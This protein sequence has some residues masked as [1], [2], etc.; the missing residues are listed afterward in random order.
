[1]EDKSHIP[2][3]ERMPQSYTEPGAPIEQE[4]DEDMD[5]E[6][7]PSQEVEE[8]EITDEEKE[9]SDEDTEMVDAPTEEKNIIDEIDTTI[10][11]NQPGSVKASEKDEDIALDVEEAQEEAEASD[12]NVVTR[13]EMPD[14][15][16]STLRAMQTPGM[17]AEDEKYDG[18]AVLGADDER[19]DQRRVQSYVAA[20]HRH[21]LSRESKM[22]SAE[23]ASKLH[24]KITGYPL[25]I[26]PNTGEVI[27]NSEE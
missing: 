15:R 13:T 27:L 16:E 23:R 14:F 6:Y 21:N 1:M 24:E 4:P 9:A 22:K 18:D 2:K 7:N 17:Y 3:Y 8:G 25:E 5:A 10:D 19:E 12:P 20:S 11:D 26:N